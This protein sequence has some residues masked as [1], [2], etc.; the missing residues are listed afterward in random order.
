MI[1]QL[2]PVIE[3]KVGKSMA[4]STIYRMLARHGWQKLAPDTY[5]RRQGT[6]GSLEKNCPKP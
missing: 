6:S 2:K 3:E 5:Q 4:L 1:P